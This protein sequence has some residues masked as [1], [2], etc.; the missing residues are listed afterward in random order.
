MPQ[1]MQNPAYVLPGALEGIQKLF[2][3]TNSVDIPKGFM[4]LVQLRTSQINGC[5]ACTLSHAQ[6][7]ANA[8]EN[9]E[10][11]ATTAAW[12]EA[13]YFSDAER[14]AFALAEAMTRLPDRSTEAITDDLWDDVADHYDEKQLSA[15]ILTIAIT[16]LFNRL[17]AT[18]KTP[19]GT[20][21]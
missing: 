14:A 4:E 9:Q 19:A 6:A 10:R 21:W 13:P 15:L 1:R 12:R 17:N 3:A 8:G 11:I 16:N 5:S 20:S 18:V 7:A 2:E